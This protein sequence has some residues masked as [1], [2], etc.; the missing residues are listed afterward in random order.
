LLGGWICGQE[1]GG[2]AATDVVSGAFHEDEIGF[3]TDAAVKSNCDEG[4]KM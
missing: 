3:D 1:A 4:R 2:D